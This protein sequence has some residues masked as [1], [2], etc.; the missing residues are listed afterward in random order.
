[1]IFEVF[2][3]DD[4]FSVKLDED[5]ADIITNSFSELLNIKTAFYQNF[6]IKGLNDITTNIVLRNDNGEEKEFSRRNFDL[7]Q[8]K[9]LDSAFDNFFQKVK[10]INNITHFKTYDENNNLMSEIKTSVI[11]RIDIENTEQEDELFYYVSKN[12]RVDIVKLPLSGDSRSTWSISFIPKQPDG[13]D[14]LMM[15]E[16]KMENIKI[17][18]TDFNNKIKSKEISFKHGDQLMCDIEIYLQINEGSFCGNVKKATIF[19]VSKH[20][21]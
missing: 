7:I 10:S 13:K 12:T 4:D 11:P 18:D 20:I 8:D 6:E 16:T 1:M 9:N 3:D 2:K 19:E 17:K 15:I 14:A 5:F 21:H